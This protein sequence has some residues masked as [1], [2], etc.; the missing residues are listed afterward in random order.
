M[1]RL[2]LLWWRVSLE[3]EVVNYWLRR[4]WTLKCQVLQQPMPM[5]LLPLHTITWHRWTIEQMLIVGTRN[6]ITKN[7][8]SKCASMSKRD[9]KRHVTIIDALSSPQY[10]TC[11]WT[12]WH[13]IPSYPWE[14]PRNDDFCGRYGG[15]P[16]NSKLSG[17]SAVVYVIHSGWFDFILP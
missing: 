10:K 8:R 6:H 12:C 5:R 9:H 14:G 3:P 11:Q 15:G 17:V 13:C 16:N 7:W 1:R 4:S 2:G